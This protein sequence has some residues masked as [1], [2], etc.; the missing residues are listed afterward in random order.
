MNDDDLTQMVNTINQ[1]MNQLSLT[2]TKKKTIE[3][4][5][6]AS[7]E[8]ADYNNDIAT[9]NYERVRRDALNDISQSYARD[10]EARQN[11]GMSPSWS[12]GD[13]GSMI[14]GTDFGTQGTGSAPDVMSTYGQVEDFGLRSFAEVMQA[15]LQKAQIDNLRAQN[16]NIVADTR[17]KEVEVENTALDNVFL[18]NTMDSRVSQSQ[19]T[20]EKVGVDVELSKEELWLK[21]KMNA[22]YAEHPDWLEA[23]QSAQKYLNEQVD[24]NIDV[25]KANVNLIHAQ[26]RNVNQN[27]RLQAEQEILTAI[28]SMYTEAQREVLLDKNVREHWN[29]VGFLIKEMDSVENDTEITDEERNEQL[30][31]LRRMYDEASGVAEQKRDFEQQDKVQDKNLQYKYIELTYRGVDSVIGELRKRRKH[32]EEKVN[33]RNGGSQRDYEVRRGRRSSA[34]GR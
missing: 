30:A 20:S 24:A 12:D 17:K 27:T 11:A 4:Q 18:A 3:R 28:E 5:L 26:V 21:Q 19:S 7:K 25:L 13:V 2:A 31:L 15:Q 9:K 1:G 29:D 33:K 14:P 16:D 32:F 6:K 22:N 8:M 10:K 34:R 23:V